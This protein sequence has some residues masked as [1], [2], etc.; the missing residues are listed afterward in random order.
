MN[1]S[2]EKSNEKITYIDIN[3]LTQD[4]VTL[5]DSSYYFNGSFSSI[6]CSFSK[7]TLFDVE[8]SADDWLVMDMTIEVVSAAINWSFEDTGKSINFRMGLYLT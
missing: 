2:Q 8:F 7:G 4:N 3:K 1:N 5:K 6:N